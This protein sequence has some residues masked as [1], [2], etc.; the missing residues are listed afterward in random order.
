[1]PRTW[2]E[3][4]DSVRF[5]T[6]ALRRSTVPA[7][8]RSALLDDPPARTRCDASLRTEEEREKGPPHTSLVRGWFPAPG[9]LNT[10]DASRK[11]AICS[12]LDARGAARAEVRGILERVVE[13]R[14]LDV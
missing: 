6:L 14:Q 10:A 7:A 8:A 5:P 11:P 1:M 4:T 9:P 3:S 2:R 13:R 12:V